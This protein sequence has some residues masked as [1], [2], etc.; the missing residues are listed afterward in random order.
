[1]LQHQDASDA[2]EARRRNAGIERFRGSGTDVVVGAQVEM[3]AAEIGLKRDV[4]GEWATRAAV[5]AASAPTMAQ[6]Y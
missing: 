6:W 4:L 5:A 3:M 1:M 2:A